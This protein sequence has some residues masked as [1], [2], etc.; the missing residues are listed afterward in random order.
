MSH[1]G[2]VEIY[3]LTCPDT[4]RVR[5]VGKANDSAER[6]KSHTREARRTGRKTP[7]YHWFRSLSEVGKQPGMV[8]LA[9]VPQGQDWR[10]VEMRLIAEHRANGKML[11]VADGGDEPHCSPETRAANGAKVLKLIQS[12][13]IRLGLRNAMWRM[14]KKAEVLKK[15]GLEDAYALHKSNLDRMRACIA[16]NPELVFYRWANNP[17]IRRSMRLP[18]ALWNG[19]DWNNGGAV[20]HGCE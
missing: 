11:N 14:G 19:I 13:P 8:V 5:Y 12:D 6:Y 17:I 16:L 1:A 9:T 7:V 18:D 20:I 4:G 10:P 2:S 15:P 3:G